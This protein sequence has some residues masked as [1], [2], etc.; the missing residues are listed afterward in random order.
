MTRVAI[1]DYG[2]MK[3]EHKATAEEIARLC[4]EMGNHVMS[5]VIK[6]KFGLVVRPR[7]DPETSEFFKYCKEANVF[8][9]VQGMMVDLNQDMDYPIVAIC[10]DIRKIENLVSIIKGSK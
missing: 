6:E 9:T 1:F 4:E 7:F 8:P 10:D 5:D 3:E 2:N